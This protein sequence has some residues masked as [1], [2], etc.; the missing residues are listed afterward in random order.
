MAS[1]RRRSPGDGALYKRASDGMWVGSVEIRPDGKRRQKR[2]YSKSRTEARR[3]LDELRAQVAAGQIPV[4]AKT[5]VAQWL[6]H[7]LEHVKKPHVRPSTYDFYE[8]AARLHIIPHIGSVRLDRLTAQQVRVMLTE[9]NTSRNAQRAHTTLK[10]ALKT[11]VN[12]GILGRNVM[13]AVE[14]PGHIKTER[15]ALPAE[16]AKHVIRTAIASSDDIH[17]TR[18][19]AAFL[20]GARPAELRG[21]EWDRVDLING[22]IVFSWQLQRHE[23]I[24]GCG[25][26]C[27]RTRP[28]WCPQATWDLP[29]NYEYRECHRT[30]IFTRPKTKSG[31]RVVPIVPELLDGLRELALQDGPNPHNLVWHHKDGRPFAPNDELRAWTR[32]LET[33]QI[34]RVEQYAARH[35]TATLLD[36]L[37]VGEEVRMA[38][39]GQSSKV[40]HRM[41]LHVDQTRARAALNQLGALLLPA[42]T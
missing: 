9:V 26:T 20:T 14:K 24:H 23:K 13:D 11:A 4:T 34:P 1:T 35:S 39:M 18:W 25:N 10:L 2:V 29:D 32:L 3:K 37:G 16:Q 31:T 36:E 27:G 15:D 22:Q 12:D 30:L 42:N 6:K 5:T 19:V 8:E 33:A 38:I 7:W 40:A 21:L 41:Y 17:P 28:S